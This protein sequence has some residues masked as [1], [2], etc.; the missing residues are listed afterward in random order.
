MRLL[1][2]TH[3]VAWAILDDA[4]LPAAVKAAIS[5][6]ANDVFVS[7][8][9]PW[10][11]AIKVGVGRWAEA[12]NLIAN[13]E[14]EMSAVNFNSLPI[15][16]RHVRLAGLMTSPHRDPFDRLL[17]AQATIEGLTL[18]TADAKLASLGA[19]VIW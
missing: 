10:E 11:I 9:S 7:I 4:K 14:N 1:L 3:V 13:F 18:V 19:P 5:D 2:D 15:S 12:S 16:L 8:V 6:V 17:A